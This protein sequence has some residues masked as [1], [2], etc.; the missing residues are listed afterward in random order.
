MEYVSLF[1]VFLGSEEM[2]VCMYV[3]MRMY[4]F[5]YLWGSK[6][7]KTVLTIFGLIDVCILL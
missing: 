6:E 3:R 2:Y 4:A 1:Y 5:K 7:S